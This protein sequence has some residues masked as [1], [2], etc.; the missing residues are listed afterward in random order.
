MNPA[1][2]SVVVLGGLGFMG[3]H[4][5]RRLVREGRK[6]R[7]FDKLYASRELIA[8]FA[9][10]VQ[11]V[12]GDILRP[13]DVIE[14]VGDAE[15]VIHLVHTTRPG[16]S[17]EDP[18]FDVASNVVA[19]ANWL[20]LLGQTK[21]RKILFVSSGGTVYGPPQTIPIAEDHP[22]NPISSYGITKLAIEKYVAMYAEL[23]GIDYLLLRPSNV[24]GEGQRLNVGQ[25]L[26]GVLADRALRG[27]QIE[28]WGSGDNLRDYLHIDDMVS[29]TLA[30]LA[31]E[32]TEKVF[33]IASGQ[34]HS[35]NQIIEKLV[36]V[37]GFRPALSYVPDRGFDVQAN[38]LDATRLSSETGWFPAVDMQEGIERTVA[39]VRSLSVNE[40]TEL[41]L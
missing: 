4:I 34:G 3:S 26:I 14:A 13:H 2:N 11:V 9:A 20:P 33:N 15:V 12:E 16:S 7:I 5:C 31:Y 1:N 35:V 37:L 41:H 29:A 40:P 28:I 36:P 23:F 21:V 22:T 6:V 8:D 30:L 18:A 32:G 10:E 19:A 17:M 25:G 38:V 27:E 24:Y 39:W